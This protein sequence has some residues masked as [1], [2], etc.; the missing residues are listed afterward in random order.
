[1]EVGK[2]QA[3]E[4]CYKAGDRVMTFVGQNK[5]QTRLRNC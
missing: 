1:M 5:C 2:R 3:R 4:R